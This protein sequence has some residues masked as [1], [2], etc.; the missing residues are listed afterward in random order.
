MKC[1]IR[2]V[3]ARILTLIAFIALL[4]LIWGAFM[5]KL[6]N[7]PEMSDGERMI[8]VGRVSHAAESPDDSREAVYQLTDPTGAIWI[9]TDSG[10]PLINTVVV[11]VGEVQRTEA[12]R[13]VCHERQRFGTF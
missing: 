11:V 3:G 8:V 4:L 9:R 12:G 5:D 1:V 6:S 2:Y 13:P 10:S 7:L